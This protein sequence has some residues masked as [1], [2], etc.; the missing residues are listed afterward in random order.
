MK[1]ANHN[2][3]ISVHHL[4]Y[5]LSAI[6]FTI[7]LFFAFQM[8]QVLH[9]RDFLIA[10]KGQQEKA[11]EDSQRL[12]AQLVALIVGTQKLAAEGDKNAQN[13]VE[14]LKSIGVIP[15][16]RPQQAIPGGEPV[17]PAPVPAMMERAPSGGPVK[18]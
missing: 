5:P 16:P 6:A 15:Q 8:T 4:L 17:A 18:P 13:V 2:C 10:S 9:D 14:K 11:V 12:Q 3:S 1:E 7:F